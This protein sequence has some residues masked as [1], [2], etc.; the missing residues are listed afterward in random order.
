MVKPKTL[1]EE[2]IVIFLNVGDRV[3]R[4]GGPVASRVAFGWGIIEKGFSPTSPKTFFGWAIRIPH[5]V[6]PDTP[7]GYLSDGGSWKIS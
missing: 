6:Y 7:S 3:G 4:M 1:L 5:P 2:V